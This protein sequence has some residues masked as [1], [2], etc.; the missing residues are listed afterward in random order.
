M[1]FVEVKRQRSGESTCKFLLSL[2]TWGNYK[3]SCPQPP[4]SQ[5]IEWDE[6]IKCHQT[7]NVSACFSSKSSTKWWVDATSGVCEKWLKL[8]KV[9]L[10]VDRK[11][12]NM[13]KKSW[14]WCNFPW[15]CN[16]SLSA[17]DHCFE[18]NASFLTL[19]E[20]NMWEF[21]SIWDV[22]LTFV[23]FIESRVSKFI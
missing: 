15:D 12:E 5:F 18:A 1:H 6:W 4:P 8:T 21:W 7:S 17:S 3:C 2:W 22:H 10:K 20:W 9:E 14:E 23:S 13:W 16:F 19:I 11:L